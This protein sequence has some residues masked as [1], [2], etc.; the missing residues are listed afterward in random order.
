MTILRNSTELEHKGK[1]LC[2]PCF[3]KGNAMVQTSASTNLAKSHVAGNIQ[4][5]ILDEDDKM[6]TENDCNDGPYKIQTIGYSFVKIDSPSVEPSDDSGT[7]INSAANGPITTGSKVAKDGEVTSRSSIDQTKR[8]AMHQRPVS[9]TSDTHEMRNSANLAMQDVPTGPRERRRNEPFDRQACVIAERYKNTVTCPWWKRGDCHS[10]EDDCIFAHRLTGLESPSGKSIAKDWTCYNFYTLRR[11]YSDER[12]CYYSHTDTGLYVGVDGKASK[13]HLECWWWHHGGRC[14]LADDDCTC[15]HYTT[16]LLA[17]EPPSK[18]P[19]RRPLTQLSRASLNGTE[20]PQASQRGQARSPSYSPTLQPVTENLHSPSIPHKQL[21]S[22]LQELPNIATSLL[23]LVAQ[24]S[25]PSLVTEAGVDPRLRRAMDS[26]T[27]IDQNVETV[28]KDR[29]RSKSP[30]KSTTKDSPTEGQGSEAQSRAR[31]QQF[32]RPSMNPCKICF[33]KIFKA[34]VCT[35]CLKVT[36][37]NDKTQAGVSE[38]AAEEDISDVLND[39]VAVQAISKTT[40][41]AVPAPKILKRSRTAS[42]SNLFAS[43]RMRPDLT[44]IRTATYPSPAT[45]SL[46]SSTFL[47]SLE[48]LGRRTAEQK[49]QESARAFAGFEPDS[50]TIEV[51]MPNEVVRSPPKVS[52]LADTP[53]SMTSAESAFMKSRHNRVWD[54][55]KPSPNRIVPAKKGQTHPQEAQDDSEVVRSDSEHTNSDSDADSDA[56][57]DTPLALMRS[58][59]ENL[60]W[61]SSTSTQSPQEAHT[62][63]G[64]AT[65]PMSRTTSAPNGALPTL[66]SARVRCPT[67]IKYHRKCVHTVS[68]EFDERKC[69]IWREDRERLGIKHKAHYSEAERALIIRKAQAYENTLNGDHK[70]VDVDEDNQNNDTEAESET[71]DEGV[72]EDD[73]SSSSDEIQIS[74]RRDEAERSASRRTTLNF[75]QYDSPRML[76]RSPTP[77]RRRPTS[78]RSRSAFIIPEGMML[79]PKGPAEEDLTVVIARL[80]AKG[81]VFE[82]SDTSDDEEDELD[83]PKKIDSPMDPLLY[84]KLGNSPPK[85]SVR[86]PIITKGQIKQGLKQNIPL[87][88]RWQMAR[89]FEIFGDAH[90][91]VDRRVE[92]QE[93]FAM[94]ERKDP[95][96]LLALPDQ[97]EEKMTFP[98]FLGLQKGKEMKACLGKVSLARST[99]TMELAFKEKDM[100]PGLG[101]W[102]RERRGN[103]KEKPVFVIGM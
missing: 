42:S 33:K 96:E 26:T 53:A 48:Q 99:F 24:K 65:T 91:Q 93:V 31:P 46:G 68:G 55:N 100:D 81:V 12:Q 15:A 64:A 23:D 2:I 88:Q 92:R 72:E 82:D 51:A 71:S 20:M 37:Q 4:A 27:K 52:S 18:D 17:K 54:Q 66:R 102:G 69:Y 97:V 7:P 29:T 56:E 36:Q 73:F 39:E 74:R 67:C 101:A 75:M 32:K 35:D 1:I 6:T 16:G 60:L 21:S 87:F 98:E 40:T 62:K 38:P 9:A 19:M 76:S 11:C 84:H 10:L 43:K 57:S 44:A 83:S 45:S 63:T 80:K 22:P 25:N 49:A 79:V 70:M 90:K 13:K 47:P 77:D 8:T 85:Q 78:V 94:V 30:V 58:R 34:I 59:S 86:L 3:H 50:S 89:N 95:N 103:R 5:G 41:F 14:R 28:V 61:S